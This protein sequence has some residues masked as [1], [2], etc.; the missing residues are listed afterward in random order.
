M[1]LTSAE[2]EKLRR[3]RVIDNREIKLAEVINELL[4]S[5]EHLDIAVGYFFLSGLELIK[6]KLFELME[7][8]SA[9]IRILIGNQTNTAT[10]SFLE[11]GI[12][13]EHAAIKDAKDVAE[14]TPEDLIE[15]V[16]WMR[17][18]RIEF[19]V[20]TGP[21]NYFHAKSYLFHTTIRTDRTEGYAIV[22]S[23]NF[24]MS[25]LTGNTELNTISQDNFY[26]L[27]NWF[28]LIW[29]S[30]EVKDFSPELLKT[31]NESLPPITKELKYYITS[32]MTY[33]ELAKRYG[34]YIAPPPP[35][36]YMD[37]L[38][39]HQ[40][41]GVAEIK[42]R[43][44][45]YGTAILAD[46]VGLG[47]TRTAAA[48]IRAM[49][50]PKT[51][52]VVSKKLQ[53]QWRE[54]L[55][56]VHSAF[57][58]IGFISKEELARMQYHELRNLNQF[59]EFLLIDEGHQGLKNSRTKLYRNIEYMIEQSEDQQKNIKGLILTAT[60]WNNSRIDV[61]NLGR[62]F[63][64]ASK[65]SG[66]STYNE[67]LHYSIKKAAKAF[68]N[69]D[70]AFKEY[71]TDLF[72]QRTRKTYGGKEVT[73]AK[74]SFPTVE[75]VYEPG[76]EKAFSSNYERISE[77][78]LPH[79]NPMRYVGE[80]DT[81][82]SDRL[83]LLFLKRA[84]SSWKAFARTI[85]NLQS[86]LEDF[87]NDLDY[88]DNASDFFKAFQL[89]LSKWYKLNERFDEDLF[90]PFDPDFD[91]VELTAFEKTSRTNRARYV[92][93]MIEKIDSIK[94]PIAKKMINNMRSDAVED[95]RKLTGIYTDLDKAFKR[96]DEK[97]DSVRDEL[98][99]QVRLGEKVLIVTQF[100]DTALDYFSRF[101]IDDKL[102]GVRIGVV[103]GNP[104]D[105]KIGIGQ[106]N[107]TKEEL[108]R[109]FAPN[110]KNALEYLGSEEE[111]DVIIG[112]ETLSTGQNLQDSKIIMNLDLPY[113]P[114]VLE[115]RIGR[116]DRPR[117]DGQVKEIK[118]FTFPS[119]PVI[120]S[121]LKMTE[122]LRAKMSGIFH[123]TEFDDLVL[124]EYE[125][126][127]NSI[128]SKRRAE[129]KD[130]EEMLDKALDRQTVKIH[131]ET[132]SI[133]YVETQKRL[134]NFMQSET[135]IIFDEDVVDK[136][137]SFKKDGKSVFTAKTILRDVNGKLI[138]EFERNYTIS[139]DLAVETGLVEV[140]KIWYDALNGYA[141]TTADLDER[142]AINSKDR[143]EKVLNEITLH[144][145]NTHN[146]TLNNKRDLENKLGDNKANEVATN[147]RTAATGANK[148]Y[149]I[150][151]ME[152]SGYPKSLKILLD[153]LKYIE[154]DDNEYEY[155]EDLYEN[156]NRLW[157]NYAMY[158]ELLTDRSRRNVPKEKPFKKRG[159]IQASAE[160]SSTQWIIG[161]ISITE[162]MSEKDFI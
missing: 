20:Y 161:H 134:W 50:D 105:I 62:L 149:I 59:Y 131:A 110:S 93:K 25:G 83:K 156:I 18:K 151:K 87:L 103:T 19:K 109:R 79:M 97:Y 28:E 116:I 155:V 52:I 2:Y 34:K 137:T 88:I 8:P 48:T 117:P 26:A 35:G 4:H 115:Q 81:F 82:T 136:N 119:M 9:R 132:H 125:D 49:G 70:E 12:S 86:K 44:D 146:N 135:K 160:K 90:S 36:E 106:T 6:E 17:E 98:L 5:T 143:F 64:D 108:L 51:L 45:R 57:D 58:N 100:R 24:S 47:K 89:Q 114:M 128:L 61:F 148:N 123:D 92:R 75:I 124:P 65:V 129:S 1:S 144:N 31:V 120:E 150:K 127:L 80:G 111:L 63:L 113:N 69:D 74:R 121:E 152:E 76:K 77:L 39:P 158:F 96:I 139:N 23:S 53:K 142:I 55:A 71:W 133:D 153:S 68:E 99:G 118:I 60:P 15:V 138:E 13:P 7:K 126:F 157:D 73:F 43:L 38:Y 107:Y 22:G 40:K 54:E 104:E 29:N 130:V 102:K 37:T 159:Y 21:A 11:K 141:F 94:K 162:V 66:A 145:V 84:D 3:D 42:N 72:L 27:S 16:K 67:Y 112:T 95:I 147:I 122:R 30:N 78:H 33:L 85:E 140:E 56:V 14:S 101:V 91:D 41:I 32:R 10:V 46:G 154:K